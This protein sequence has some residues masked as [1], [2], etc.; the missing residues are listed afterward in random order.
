M[1]SEEGLLY[2]TEDETPNSLILHGTQKHV[3][4]HCC[5]LAPAELAGKQHPA[6]PPAPSTLPQQ[7]GTQLLRQTQQE[8]Q[9]QSCCCCRCSGLQQLLRLQLRCCL[10]EQR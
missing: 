9:H 4:E 8:P 5:C 6:V 3:A 7:V 2:A 10:V 1:H